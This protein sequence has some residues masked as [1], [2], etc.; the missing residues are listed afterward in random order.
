MSSTLEF[1]FGQVG[2]V[3]G[4]AFILA[5]IFLA[6]IIRERVQRNGGSFVGS[7]RELTQGIG[8]LTRSVDRVD[9]RLEQLPS[10]EDIRS[11]AREN[12]ELYQRG[13]ATVLEKIDEVRRTIESRSQGQRHA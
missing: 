5:A 11:V 6:L 8:Q 3:G 2:I 1:F 10:M 13:H 9:V 12:Q 7:I 4:T